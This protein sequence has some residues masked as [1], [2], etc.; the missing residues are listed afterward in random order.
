MA[1]FHIVFNTAAKPGRGEEY[2]EWCRVQH[3]PDIMRVPGLVSAKRFKVMGKGGEDQD[4]FVA[5]LEVECD[6][7]RDVMREIG[8]RN[9]TPEMPGS[10]CYD[11]ASVTV[12]FTELEGE[13]NAAA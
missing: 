10:D 3:F 12:T 7:P 13:W 5:I 2:S 1:R 8:R 11:P 6:D 9:G 4:R